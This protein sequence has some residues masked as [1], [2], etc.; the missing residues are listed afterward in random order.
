MKMSI[1]VERINV[2]EKKRGSVRHKVVSEKRKIDFLLRT[3]KNKIC[4]GFTAVIH[5]G[6]P[7]AS[8]TRGQE[9]PLLL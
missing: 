3:P 8:F 2:S 7:V 5:S 4:A 1:S 6:T 9:A